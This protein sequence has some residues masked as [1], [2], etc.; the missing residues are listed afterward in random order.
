[1]LVAGALALAGCSGASDVGE[2][3]TTAPVANVKA[4][5]H[6]FSESDGGIHLRV[7]SGSEVRLSGRDSRGTTVPVLHYEWT[8][9]NPAAEAVA[10]VKR[11]EST[12]KLRVPDVAGELEFRLTVTDGNGQSD[13][14]LVTIAVEEARDPDAFLT[15]AA[16]G[17]QF[18]VVAV[19][20]VA[21]ALA[22]D[23]PFELVIE[24]RLTY[25]DLEGVRH[26]D[27]PLA[28]RT[29]RLAGRWLA[30]T[31]TGGPDCADA[32]NPRFAHPLPPLAMDEV[33]EH[34]GPDAPQLAIDPATIDDAVLRLKLTLTPAGSLPAGVA[35]GLCVLDADDAIVADPAAGSAGRTAGPGFT[36]AADGVSSETVVTHDQIAGTASRA[37]DTRASAEA[38]YRTIDDAGAYS[39]KATLSGWLA[40]A[41]LSDGVTDWEAMRTSLADSTTGAHATYLN[42]FDLGFGRDM[43]A[44]LGACDDG[45]TP[46][47]LAEATAGACDVYSVVV[48]YGSLEG[49]ARTLQPIIAVAMEYSRA[50]ASGP[51]RIVKFYTY[52]PTRHGD[53]RRVLS[54]DLDGRGEKFMPASCTACHSGTPRGL[55]ARDATLYGNGGDVGSAFLAWDLDSLLYSDTDSGFS[56]EGDPSFTAS[57][58]ALVARFTRAEQEPAFRRLNQLAYLTYGDERRFPLARELLEGWYGG[59]GL[60]SPTFDG[61]HVPQGW[62]SDTPGNPAD[63]ELIYRDVFAHYCRAC[64]MMQVPGPLGTGQFAIGSYADFA[65]AASLSTM[66][67]SG[68]MPLARLTMDRFWLPSPGGDGRSAAQVLSEHLRD[69][70]D[71]A[72]VEFGRP[73]PV[74]VIGGL[75]SPEDTL[76]RGADYLLDARGS[77]LFAGSAYAW[78]LEKPP[79]S[80]AQLTFADSATPTLTGVDL[81][82][83]Y[84]LSLSVDGTDAPTCAEAT[85]DGSPATSCETR[86]R[87][88]SVPLVVTIA[89]QDPLAPVPLDAGVTTALA[90]G[91]RT[92]SPG[93]GV[94]V[95]RQVEIA[96]NA[97]G[98]TAAACA[99]TF[100]VCVSVPAGALVDAPV[101][102]SV[103][104]ED[105][106][107]DRAATP[108]AFSVYVPAVLTSRVCRR[109]VPIRPNDGSAYPAVTI[110]VGD[111][112]VGAGSRGLRFFDAGGTEIPGGRFAYTPPAG[113]MTTF[114]TAPPDSTRRVLS[115]DVA[116]IDFRA[117][118]A[119]ATAADADVSGMVEIGFVG[120]DDPLWSDAARPG[121]A[122]SF[123]RL[124][125]ALALGTTC[126]S[127]HGRP[128]TSIGFLGAT[129]QEGYARMRCGVDA[130]EPLAT[131]YVVLAE[132]TTSA[133]L[134]KPAGE[135]NHSFRGLNL[136]SDMV[137]SHQAL[138]GVKQWIEQGAY[139][140]ELGTEPACP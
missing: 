55:D 131:P 38:Y 64:H 5:N 122:V 129:V 66:L 71:D 89:D 74:A 79:G 140:T 52:A 92:D 78:R 136:T 77:T 56:H 27:F 70:G 18:T 114:V 88:D 68:H 73:G 133:L 83:S 21:T 139:D 127:C 8:A 91:L 9:L 63:A 43:Y 118:Y 3:P 97:A 99:N 128:D 20:S 116:R 105:A 115:D 60:P 138:P 110:D 36:T 72:T 7:R 106:D 101:P 103:V 6:P 34:V 51:R 28:M 117:E 37:R 44:R 25:T 98:I 29:T 67:Q 32:R 10:L 35:A 69:D 120:H 132:P 123:E 11:N 40:R 124:R 26:A 48:N 54:V 46:A 59:A 76:V 102:G 87:R 17:G 126:G 14:A 49:A 50:P 12:V 13:D 24:P 121:D 57:E 80:E 1:V 62:R 104:V 113:R 65:G 107:G 95:I 53:F 23:L 39:A 96:D 109:D 130:D 125:A 134:L 19:T 16:A 2:Q 58:R 93:D 135:L 90:I 45:A 42:N 137:V 108:A 100:S 84:S 119:D 30:A 15:Y 112:V 22:S 111:C 61:S 31:G 85:S 86:V 33:L 47:T 81:K 75:A 4:L 82:G 41:G 94:R